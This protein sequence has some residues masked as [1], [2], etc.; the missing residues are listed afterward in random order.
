MMIGSKLYQQRFG[1]IARLY[2]VSAL[3]ALSQAHFMVIGLGGVGSWVAEALSRS[4]VATITLM[5][6][7]D[8]CVTNINRQIQALSSTVGELKSE[9]LA[10]RLRDINPE[11]TVHLVD[12]FLSTRNLAQMI[13]PEHHV[14]IEATDAASVKA[15]CIAYCKARKIR[16]ITIGSAGGKTD[17]RK[18]TSCDLG[19]TIS[20]PMLSKVRQLLY[21]RH[22]FARDTKRKFMVEAVFSTEQAVFPKPDGNVSQQKGV[23]QEGV[24]LDCTA[25]FG[26]A[27][28]LTATMGMVAAERAIVKY[29]AD[30]HKHGSKVK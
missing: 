15:A 26:S 9:A 11:I 5:D 4:G 12:D 29:L 30:T 7:D 20:D 18:V 10:K 27:T 3:E 16:L 19:K 1:G 21:K 17:P 28:M 22:K 6:M 25:G 13:S 2:G 14:V 8:I 23:M 24:K